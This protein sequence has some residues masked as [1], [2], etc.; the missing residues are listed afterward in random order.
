M[1]QSIIR[2]GPLPGDRSCCL[3]TGG[4]ALCVRT[5]R[6]GLVRPSVLR[7]TLAVTQVDPRGTRVIVAD[8]D[9]LMRGGLASLLEQGGYEVVG[10]AGDG[11]ELLRL[12]RE[13]RPDL[14]VIDIRM[15]PDHRTEGLQAAHLIRKELPQMAILLL[16]AHV[17]LAQA[18]T[19]LATGCGSGYLLKSRV[20][21]LD[22]F[23]DAAERVSRGG[24]VV[25]PLLVQ[26]LITAREV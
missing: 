18:M 8:D 2:L 3:L 13:C 16:S 7:D 1:G 22:E 25:D 12:V 20:T 11:S 26:E 17:E 19:L 21:E 23:L 5:R 4:S 24:S 15:P 14:A 6:L 10:R 9:V